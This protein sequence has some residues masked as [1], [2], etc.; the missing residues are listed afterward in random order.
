M[1]TEKTDYEKENIIPVFPFTANLLYC[2]NKD[3][4]FDEI[5]DTANNKLNTFDTT[6]ENEFNEWS[7]L[8]SN[9]SKQFR[10]NAILNSLRILRVLSGREKNLYFKNLFEMYFNLVLKL[11]LSDSPKTKFFETIFKDEIDLDLFCENI[12]SQKG[13]ISET[14]SNGKVI[15]ISVFK[16]ISIKHKPTLMYL[17]GY[18]RPVKIEKITYFSTSKVYKLLYSISDSYYMGNK[19]V[20][21]FVK[22]K[23]GCEVLLDRNGKICKGIKQ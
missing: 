2:I 6:L 18:K 21:N 15:Y 17:L 12:I 7:L 10:H 20:P 8:L 4:N 14:L 19:V 3:I 22:N 9:Y 5:T 1:E 11:D 16:N 23:I 13:K